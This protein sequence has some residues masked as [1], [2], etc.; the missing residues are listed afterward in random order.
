MNWIDRILKATWPIGMGLALA[1]LYA[2]RFVPQPE[3]PWWSGVQIVR[4]VP[5]CDVQN[6]QNAIDGL[7]EQGEAVLIGEGIFV[8]TQPVRIGPRPLGGIEIRGG[9]FEFGA[10]K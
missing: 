10:A 3:L 2:Y 9:T 5:C 1:I 6:L 8:L 4:Y 7:P